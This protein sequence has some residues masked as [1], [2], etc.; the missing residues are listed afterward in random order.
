M[1]DAALRMIFLHRW[2]GY[3]SVDSPQ[4]GKGALRVHRSYTDYDK[5]Y[6]VA[7][8]IRDERQTERSLKTFYHEER[9][10]PNN[11]EHEI[12]RVERETILPRIEEMLSKM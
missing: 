6:D 9:F 12:E 5:F 2:S 4:G 11:L 8:S 3:T 1:L 10:S 7:W